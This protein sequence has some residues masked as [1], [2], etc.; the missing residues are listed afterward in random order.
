MRS[1]HVNWGWNF[2]PVYSVVHI[3][4]RLRGT[5]IRAFVLSYLFKCQKFQF[6]RHKPIVKYSLCLYKSFL[7]GGVIDLQH[8]KLLVAHEQSSTKDQTFRHL[9]GFYIKYTINT[10]ISVVIVR[11]TFI[12]DQRWIVLKRMTGL[13][14]DFCLTRRSPYPSLNHLK[15][16]DYPQ[17]F[18]KNLSL[19]PF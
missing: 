1:T 5:A 13:L 19:S 17:Q 9:Q 12:S 18:L 7:F 15:G 14:M 6:R 10:E 8:N 16:P 3:I 11:F 2:H 4:E